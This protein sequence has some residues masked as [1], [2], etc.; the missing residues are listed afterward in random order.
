MPDSTIAIIQPN[1]N[2]YSE[3]FIKNHIT[4]LKGRKI[5]L[6]GGSFPLYQEQDRLLIRSPIDFF[7]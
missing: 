3:T 4:Y 1:K 6:Y 5:I 7:S 2:A